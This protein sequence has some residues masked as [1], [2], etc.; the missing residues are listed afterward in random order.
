[1]LGIPATTAALLTSG[2]LPSAISSP[3]RAGE[4]LAAAQAAD[5]ELTRPELDAT[6]RGPLALIGAYCLARSGRPLGVLRARL[7]LAEAIAHGVSDDI[8]LAEAL[9]HEPAVTKSWAQAA[10]WVRSDDEKQTQWAINFYLKLLVEHGDDP[11]GD[12]PYT[13]LQSVGAEALVIHDHNKLLAIPLLREV[14]AVVPAQVLPFSL[15]TLIRD[16]WIALIDAT[17]LHERHT[18]A[19]SV[20][21]AARRWLPEYL[22][23]GPQ[24]CHFTDPISLRPPDPVDDDIA[25]PEPYAL[26]ALIESGR[27]PAELAAL[28][29]R[30]WGY[31][32]ED[33]DAALAAPDLD[34]DV[35]GPLTLAGA[36]AYACFDSLM[37]GDT[38]LRAS[39]AMTLLRAV[40]RGVDKDAPGDGPS[41]YLNIKW[42]VDSRHR[43][44][45]WP[46]LLHRADSASDD[47][48][49][50]LAVD[51]YNYV[52][53]AHTS[54]PAPEGL[55]YGTLEHIAKKAEGLHYRNKELARPLLRAVAAAMPAATL[56]YSVQLVIRDVWERLD[57]P[58]AA[59]A[60]LPSH[61]TA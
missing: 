29:D 20:Q 12:L 36:Y 30:G 34:P 45:E 3:L 49:L 35:R 24:A 4:W 27:L 10:A 58:D 59:R 19:L 31:L 28:A 51:L 16:A 17:S 8:G 14:V 42:Q 21:A 33:I 7:L 26:T 50:P 2:W 15:Q 53:R 38:Y 41:L 40:P 5:R 48:N 37:S 23:T 43:E 1:M 44:Q 60:W 54:D 47:G 6:T 13:A 18:E 52:L 22:L 55:L 25:G 39:R 46:E 11:S 57:D 9:A 56:P 61:L 32:A